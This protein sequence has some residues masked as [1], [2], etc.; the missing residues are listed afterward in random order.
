MNISFRFTACGD[1]K[2]IFESETDRQ[3]TESTDA[4]EVGLCSYT[5][6]SDRYAITAEHCILPLP[7]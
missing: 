2:K 3:Q 7:G 1:S 4:G 6:V 5:V